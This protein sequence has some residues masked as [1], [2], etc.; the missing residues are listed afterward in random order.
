MSWQP[1]IDFIVTILVI[2]LIGVLGYCSI[3]G[4]GLKDMYYEIKEIIEGKTAEAK[5]KIV[6]G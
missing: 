5:E 3:R 1:L 2:L 4:T 6:Y